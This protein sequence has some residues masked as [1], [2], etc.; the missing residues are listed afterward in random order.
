ME[1]NKTK[2]IDFSELG[3]R[4]DRTLATAVNTG[5]VWTEADRQF[6]RDNMFE[7]TI[8]QLAFG[9]GRTAFAIETI[10]TKDAEFLNLREEAGDV[11]G[12]RNSSPK[13]KVNEGRDYRVISSDADV[14]FNFDD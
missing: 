6:L 12:T 5:Q 13:A 4:Q 10:L 11:P 2:K 8:D 7:L 9:L 14:L 3:L 1:R